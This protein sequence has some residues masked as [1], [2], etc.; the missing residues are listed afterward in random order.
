[1]FNTHFQ[2]IYIKL[3]D[4][5]NLNCK[6]C[7]QKES[8]RFLQGKTKEDCSLSDDVI[9]WLDNYRNKINKSL[10]PTYIV[11]WGGEPLIHFETI[12]FIVNR[13]GNS[14]RYGTVTNGTLLTEEVVDFFN[15]HQIHFALSHDGE[16]TEEVK[17]IDVLKND[18]IRNL[19]S[20]I[21]KKSFISVVTSKNTSIPRIYDYFAENGFSDTDV[22]IVY[23]SNTDDD[24]QKLIYTDINLNEL[25]SA[26]KEIIRRHEQFLAGNKKFHQEHRIIKRHITSISQQLLNKKTG[27]K[28]FCENCGVIARG[29]E[30]SILPNGKILMCHNSGEVIGSIKDDFKTIETNR[31]NAKNKYAKYLECEN[32]D[33]QPICTGGCVHTTEK[34]SRKWCELRKV[35]L[36]NLLV[37][38]NKN[39]EKNNIPKKIGDKMLD[40]HFSV[41]F[42]TLGKDCNFNCKYCLQDDGFTHQNKDIAKPELSEKLLRFLDNYQYERTKIMLWG[43][44]PLLYFGSIKKLVNRYDKKFDWGTIT[45]GSLLKQE[46]IDFF[47]EHNISLTVS[48]DGEAT[49]YTRGMDVLKN[50]RIKNLIQSCKNFTGFSSVYSSANDNYRKLF[51]YFASQGFEKNNSGV[52]LIYNTGDTK[53]L[54]ELTNIDEERY[55]QTLR[56]LFYGYEQQEFHNDSSYFKEWNIVKGMLHALKDSIETKGKSEFNCSCSSCTDMLNIDYNGDVYICHNSTYKIGTVEDDYKRIYEKYIEYLKERFTPKCKDCSISEICQ[57]ACLLLTKKGQENFCKL[58]KIQIGMLCDW[59]TNLKIESPEET[60][61][62]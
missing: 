33:F 30:V 8:G 5:C 58:R 41:I 52:D 27:K 13:Y 21:N 1:M 17:K 60:P 46:I 45:N 12:K 19:F 59:L 14:F 29:T 6:Y 11:L 49:E 43:G 62:E 18:K 9:E 20:K 40:K 51:Q 10:S 4:G 50:D 44:E 61:N 22:D 38:L 16:A 15:K 7:S 32:C 26:W 53:A 23:C 42:L 55:R 54:F 3:G 31:S 35:A 39:I 57:G 56:E 36:S 25:D 2:K 24:P 47:D 28:L 37:Y 34:G 48:H